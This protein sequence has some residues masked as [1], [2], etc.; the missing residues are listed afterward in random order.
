[1]ILL[2]KHKKNNYVKQIKYYSW[3]RDDTL[4]YRSI[5]DGKIKGERWKK[6]KTKAKICKPYNFIKIKS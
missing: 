6:A 1:M 4:M 2:Y 3:K 5:I